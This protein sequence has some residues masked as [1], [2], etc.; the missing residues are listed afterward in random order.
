MIPPILEFNLE[1][2]NIDAQ[3]RFRL[4]LES[5]NDAAYAFRNALPEENEAELFRKID[6]ALREL[7][8]SWSL[9]AHVKKHS[10]GDNTK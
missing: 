10:N 3:S 2:E 4:A 1:R 9:W 8:L 5:V 6:S 7:N